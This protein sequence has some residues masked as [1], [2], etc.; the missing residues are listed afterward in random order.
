MTYW[1]FPSN[2]NSYD[3]YSAFKELNC[4]QWSQGSCKAEVGDI[5]Y[6]YISKP[7]QAIAFK[8]EIIQ[9]NVLTFS[10]NEIGYFKNKNYEKFKDG[11]WFILKKINEINPVLD[12]EHLKK[13][14]L[15]GNIQNKRT[16]SDDIQNKIDNFI[17]GVKISSENDL[18]SQFKDG[19]KAVVYSTKYERNPKNR[20]AAIAY[21]GCYCHACN[22]N[23][24]DK[25]GDLGKGFIEVHHIKPVSSLKS[26]TEINPQKD[27]IPLCSNCHRMIHRRKDSILTVEE[28]KSIIANN[29]MQSNS[30][31]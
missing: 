28:L 14:G 26:E 8:T 27:L 3:I 9:K 13:Y 20:E 16:L 17:Y 30:N 1:V 23:F 12:I 7:I 29:N 21:Q 31:Y 11:P 22:F 2:L 10:D 18:I 6:I 19:K 4:I 15:K 5:V 25:Y 24:K